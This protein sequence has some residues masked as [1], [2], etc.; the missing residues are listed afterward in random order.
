[1]LTTIHGAKGAEW[2]VVFLVGLEEGLL[3]HAR[4]LAERTPSR[5]PGGPSGSDAD[6]SRSLLEEE[7]LR[8]A[9]VAVTRPRAAL[10]L[11]HCRERRS[12]GL[13]VPRRPSRFLVALP[14]PLT[15]RTDGPA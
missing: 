7:E 12:D 10:Y 9:F 8:L 2:P 14:P 11:S 1:M 4:S 6:P 3:P 15:E 5:P 13:P